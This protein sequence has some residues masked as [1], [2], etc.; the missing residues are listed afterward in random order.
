MTGTDIT[1][2]IERQI[3]SRRM[4]PPRKRHY[5]SLM[6]EAIINR[7]LG[8]PC[9]YF[10]DSSLE[11]IWWCSIF[12]VV[13]PDD[14]PQVNSGLNTESLE[15]VPASPGNTQIGE[16]DVDTQYHGPSAWDFMTA[17]HWPFQQNHSHLQWA[18]NI[19][20]FIQCYT[21]FMW[22]ALWIGRG[23]QHIGK[24]WKTCRLDG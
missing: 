4:L 21:Q 22:V 20:F 7:K 6:K 23:V 9:I 2:T 13:K 10:H 1:Y 24:A 19:L 12:R 3:P 8:K 14:M 11:P 18:G 17:D 5:W 15:W 16:S